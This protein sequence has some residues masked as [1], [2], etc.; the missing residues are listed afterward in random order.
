M[1]CIRHKLDIDT[2]QKT[3]LTFVVFLP[4]IHVPRQGQESPPSRVRAGPE[5]PL[6]SIKECARW[7]NP[8]YVLL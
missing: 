8:P 5:N 6:Q 1:S 7:P 3:A 4:P 2:V